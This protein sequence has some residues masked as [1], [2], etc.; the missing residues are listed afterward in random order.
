MNSRCLQK[1][2]GES[3]VFFNGLQFPRSGDQTLPQIITNI[4]HGFC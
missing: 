2:G 3:F 4:K 1:P